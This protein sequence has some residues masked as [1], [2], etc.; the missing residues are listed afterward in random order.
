MPLR[1]LQFHTALLWNPALKS[2]V[3]LMLNSR[4][5]YECIICQMEGRYLQLNPAA[6]VALY[7]QFNLADRNEMT[8]IDVQD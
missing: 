4:R 3:E 1:D 6:Y 8:V 5:F 2:Q 7:P